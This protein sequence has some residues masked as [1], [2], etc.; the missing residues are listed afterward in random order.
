MHFVQSQICSN[1]SSTDS[2]NESRL[3]SFSR[4]TTQREAKP[5]K[6]DHTTQRETT[7]PKGR[8]HHIKGDHTTQRVNQTTQ[9]ETKPPKGKPFKG[10]GMRQK[11][12]R[13]EG[14]GKD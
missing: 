5:P 1:V 11:A 4:Q 13:I 6:G 8:P 9:R 3:A 2:P 14:T 10:K 12:M 7:P